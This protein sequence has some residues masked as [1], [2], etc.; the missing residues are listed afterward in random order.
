MV[1]YAGGAAWALMQVYECLG[2]EAY[3]YDCGDPPDSYLTHVVT[4]V[5][6]RNHN[7][8]L[9][10]AQTGLTLN[11]GRSPRSLKSTFRR[12]WSGKSKPDSYSAKIEK[13]L[14]FPV[15]NIDEIYPES[16]MIP[17]A[18]N[19][20]RSKFSRIRD[21]VGIYKSLVD[22]SVLERHPWWPET[23]YF[24]EQAGM[25]TPS[26]LGLL[27]FPLGVANSVHGW[28]GLNDNLPD[29]NGFKLLSSIK[30]AS[31]C[32]FEESKNNR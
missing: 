27:L 6:S 17:T 21:K 2:Y 12:I 7:W 31:R 4:L 23:K 25:S 8:Y 29:S 19:L 22:Y 28:V 9:H 3:T 30:D 5:R 10:C 26:P 24:L 14:I 20:D 13:N 11:F 15:D 18:V 16:F 1:S 32:V